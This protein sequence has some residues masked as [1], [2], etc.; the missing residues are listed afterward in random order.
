[1]T[2]DRRM[3]PDREAPLPGSPEAHAQG[4]TCPDPGDAPQT[5]GHSAGHS[6]GRALEIDSNC[7]VHGLAAIAWDRDSERGP[8]DTEGDIVDSAAEPELRRS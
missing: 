6:A 4:C 8:I 3:T 1:M 2:E 7:P 5:A